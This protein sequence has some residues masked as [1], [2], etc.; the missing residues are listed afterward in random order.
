MGSF[1]REAERQVLPS[2]RHKQTAEH[3]RPTGSA[4]VCLRLLNTYRISWALCC[5]FLQSVREWIPPSVHIQQQTKPH[6]T[7]QDEVEHWQQTT[8]KLTKLYDKN[9]TVL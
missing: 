4:P 5:L 3:T 6:V 2:R 1:S 9:D 7:T 8:W